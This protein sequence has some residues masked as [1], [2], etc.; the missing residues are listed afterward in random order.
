M[1]V[2]CRHGHFAF[3]PRKSSDLNRFAQ[4]FGVDLVRE[5]DYYTFKG[6]AGAPDYSLALKP[7][8][9]LLPAIKTYAGKPWEVM[10]ENG[11]VFNVALG[12]VVPK[13]S[14]IGLADINQVGF[15]FVTNVPLLQPGVRTILGRQILSYSGEF[16]EDKFYLRILEYTYE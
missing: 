11:F 7:Y 6:L 2:L 8:M 13:L 12:L 4:S 15:Y 10:R 16:Y 14:I 5:E 1:R 9:N 3:Y